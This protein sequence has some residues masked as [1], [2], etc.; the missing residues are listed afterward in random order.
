MKYTEKYVP[1]GVDLIVAVLIVAPL[2]RA[3]AMLLTP[4]V[5]N[6]LVRIG[7]IIQSS[8]DTSPV[9]MGIILGVSLP[10]SVQ[11]H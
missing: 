1:D 8:T 4:V 6:T 3:I 11:R 5:N 10:S 7:D 9:I 2:S